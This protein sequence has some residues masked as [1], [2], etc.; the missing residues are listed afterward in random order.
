[1]PIVV[2]I[3]LRTASKIYHFD[4]GSFFDLTRGE[5]VIVETARGQA[6]G[7]VACPPREVSSQDIRGQLKPVIRRTTAWD[8]VQADQF[9]RRE[10]ETLTE[11][12]T[13]AERHRLTMKVV[14]VEYSFDGS[15][16]TVYFSSE[17][18]ID[19]R[20]L[21]REL[22]KEFGVSVEM[23]QIGVR[24]EAKLLD[25]CGRCG[26]QLCCAGWMQEFQP[27]SIR[28]AKQQGL[29]LNPS[30]ISGVCGRL[31]CCLCHED[32]AY[33]EA[34]KRLPAKR[35]KVVTE[36]GEGTV[37]RVHPLKETVTVR[38]VN[39]MADIEVPVADLVT[40]GSQGPKPQPK[41]QPEENPPGRSTRSRRR[42]RPSR[43]G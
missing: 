2:G 34:L 22:S 10:A 43:R 8:A 3:R 12:R 29:P 7:Q 4:P 5:Y 20:S 14:A 15:R 41:P 38:L 18:R 1:M 13:I 31:L 35:S 6:M 36:H 30:E 25:G 23:R 37:R 32:K 9:Q 33:A 16:L 11:T 17:S 40:P 21:V 19:F 24:D 42:R 28:L 39:T 27:V 26:Y